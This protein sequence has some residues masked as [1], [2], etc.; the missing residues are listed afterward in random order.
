MLVV[1]RT[2]VRLG[3]FQF[4]GQGSGPFLPGEIALLGETNG[5]RE[6]LSLPG[7]GKDRT[8]GVARESGKG[9]EIRLAQDSRPIS[10]HK[11]NRAERPDR[12]ITRARRNGRSR[13]A[14]A[15]LR[16]T[17]RCYRGKRKRRDRDRRCLAVRARSAVGAC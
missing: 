14:A 17:S 1:V 11:R 10:L 16:Q 12:P 7:L 9:G 15:S 13:R 6:R 5:H 2:V 8:T 3:G 4:F